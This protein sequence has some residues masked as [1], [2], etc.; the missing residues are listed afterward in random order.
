M[1]ISFKDLKDIALKL[2]DRG[3]KIIPVAEKKRALCS[4]TEPLSRE[5]L[6]TLI[7]H[8]S[9]IGV[10]LCGGPV[11]DKYTL[12]LI[13]VDDPSIL[14][15]TPHLKS[16]MDST[17]YW[18]T[19][20]RCP[21]CFN[22]HVEVLEPGYRFKCDKC[23]IEFLRT[24]AERGIGIAVLTDHDVVSG[25]RRHG[26]VELLVN[27]YQVIPPSLHDSGLLYE[28][29]KPFNFNEQTLGILYLPAE[30]FRKVL[31]EIV[32]LDLEGKAEEKIQVQVLQKEKEEKP[33]Q[34]RRLK[35]SEKEKIVELTKPAYRPGN[36]QYMCLFLS[37]WG[38]KAG[39][40]P[41]DM[42]EI[43]RRLHD[44]TKDEDDLRIRGSCILYSYAKSGYNVSKNDIAEALSV[45]PYGPETLTQNFNVKGK[46]GIQEILEEYYG[47]EKALEIIKELEE[48]FQT[49]SPFRDSVVEI[50]D[51]EKEIY[52][53]ANL[54]KLITARAIRREKE[55]RMVYK[56]RVASGTLTE[57]TVYINPLGGITKYQV[58]WESPTRPKPLVMGPTCLEDIIARLK[59]EGLVMN[60]RLINDVIPAL[61]EGYIRKGKAQM[62]TEVETPGFYLIKEGEREKIIAVK[63][64]VYKPGPEEVREALLF[65]NELAER[66]KNPINILD[67]F[68]M[69]IKWCIVAPF[70]YVLKELGTHIPHLF[71]YGPPNTRKTTLIMIGM[72]IY[73]YR[74]PDIPEGEWEIVGSSA[75]TEARLG[76]WLEHGSFPICIREPASIFENES[77]KEMIKGS[78]EGKIARGKYRRDQTWSQYLAI[79]PL[80]FTSNTYLPKDP[81][82]MDSKRIFLITYSYA[83]ALRTDN[84]EHRELIMKF[85]NEVKPKLWK[86]QAIGKYIASRILEDP[87]L[88]KGASWINHSWIDK[89]E[90]LLKDAYRYAGLEVPDWVTL[91]CIN[92]QISEVYEDKREALRGFIIKRINDEYNRFVGRVTVETKEGFETLQRAEL[93]LKERAK[94]VI[95]KQLIPWLIGKEETIYMTTGI[96]DDLQKEK[97]NIAGD[98]KS[99]AEMLDWE[100]ILIKPIKIGGKTTSRSVIK[101]SLEDFL[102]FLEI[103]IE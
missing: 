97:Y 3:L 44:E 37:G 78:I 34:L 70:D 65:L 8:P 57:V 92:E 64:E 53:I 30:D 41:R 56:E 6:S 36:R 46:T 90:E 10:G 74:Y 55:N 21:R 38:A 83:E 91:R 28:F 25:T 47:E 39:I 43:I 11:W 12:V 67:R 81:A 42:A 84:P 19:G 27:N 101:V 54:R 62:K 2:H 23:N 103:S 50:L 22:K 71:Q 40:D 102:N 26:A 1:S 75:N 63:Y 18:F 96:L 16:L 77:L 14:N 87:N 76:Y 94:T 88:I 86:L 99:L 51:F 9:C 4:W 82:L 7:D 69:V 17:V 58:K 52:A 35:E 48:I 66:Y 45:E 100:Y 59:A 49:I 80:S 73:G 93:G 61:I 29:G 31:N 98:L 13:D 95:E 68:S 85:E 32:D 79:A 33:K 20:P 15:K 72:S 89:A 5:K 24:E 60:S